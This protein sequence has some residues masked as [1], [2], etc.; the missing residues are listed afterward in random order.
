[1]IGR[2]PDTTQ[3]CKEGT[4]AWLGL[5]SVLGQLP[6]E[7]TPAPVLA[8]QKARLASAPTKNK[9]KLLVLTATVVA[10]LGGGIWVAKGLG[11]SGGTR[12]ATGSTKDSAA[13]ENPQA[14][15][16]TEITQRV[17]TSGSRTV[18]ADFTNQEW[19]EKAFSEALEM[20]KLQQRNVDGMT[21]LFMPNA[22]NSVSGWVKEI[23]KNSKSR[24]LIH[25]R[26]G[27]KDGPWACYH[28][29]EQLSFMGSYKNGEKRGIQESWY[30]NGQK[31]SERLFE[32]TVVS[33]SKKWK[34]NGEVWPIVLRSFAPRNDSVA[35]DSVKI[36]R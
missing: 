15:E 18:D 35:N 20:D 22:E 16:P 17:V 8:P 14:L 1:M 3:V 25:I 31:E 34:P 21:R 12:S 19:M 7:Q 29:N 36:L 30:E 33:L 26:S 27:I 4:E 13:A 32:V 10:M 24:T 2:L 28:K 23:N 6:P 5:R 11:S 9:G